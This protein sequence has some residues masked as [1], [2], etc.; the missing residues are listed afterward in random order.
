M[1][2]NYSGGWHSTLS[3]I[4]LILNRE[5]IFIFIIWNTCYNNTGN[6]LNCH[7]STVP[8]NQV[9]KNCIRIA[10]AV[11]V[12]WLL[13]S[14]AWATHNPHI[15][16][17]SMIHGLH[18]VTTGMVQPGIRACEIP[19]IL[20]NKYCS[21]CHSAMPL[22]HTGSGFSNV[23]DGGVIFMFKWKF[24]SNAIQRH[25][26]YSRGWPGSQCVRLQ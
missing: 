23:V 11:A 13:L 5:K 1:H 15:H 17:P 3:R 10:D 22:P 24:V 2:S 16:P 26:F 14:A 6:F 21:R 8:T 25:D 20:S 12:T 18:Q 9:M 7:S 4:L 19:H